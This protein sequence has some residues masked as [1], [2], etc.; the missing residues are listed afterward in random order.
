MDADGAIVD[1]HTACWDI[2][3]AYF[4]E[5]GLVKQQLNSF[6]EFVSAGVRAVVKDV[7]P[8]EIESASQ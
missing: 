8:M 4:G 5:Y 7:P 1:W 3:G 6:D 2:I